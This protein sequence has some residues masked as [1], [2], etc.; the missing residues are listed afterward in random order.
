MSESIPENDSQNLPAPDSAQDK[1]VVHRCWR[2]DKAFT[3]IVCPFCYADAPSAQTNESDIDLR[4]V[5]HGFPEGDVHNCWRC[6]KEFTGVV[7]PFCYADALTTQT[8]SSDGVFYEKKHYEKKRGPFGDMEQPAAVL[9]AYIF[10]GISLWGVALIA[11]IYQHSSGESIQES[12]VPCVFFGIL[13]NFVLIVNVAVSWW[14]LTPKKEAT[15]PR[16]FWAIP[17]S[18]L[19]LPF[20]LWCAGEYLGLFP[21][22]FRLEEIPDCAREHIP[23]LIFLMMSYCVI[24]PVCEEYFFRR[25]V[26]DSFVAVVPTFA[27]VILSA[28]MFAFAHLGAI[29]SYPLLFLLGIYFGLARVYCKSIVVPMILHGLYNGGVLFLPLG[30][31]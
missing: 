5:D 22:S 16:P 14:Y 20:A 24:A 9:V 27:A 26:L 31:R 15:S 8:N 2:C 1:S 6:G 23:T 7:C 28:L 18:F 4:E 12:L 25:I 17:V 3:G 13:G 29:L 19:L 10:L 11:L 30:F 21:E